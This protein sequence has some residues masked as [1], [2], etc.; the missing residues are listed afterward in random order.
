[1]TR[2]LITIEPN[3]SIMSAIR[4][5]IK[6]NIKKLAVVKAGHLV[7]VLSLLDLVPLLETQNLSL[8]GVPKHVKRIFSIYYDPKQQLRKNCPLTMVRGMTISCLG[9]KC[10]WYVAD[11]CVIINLAEKLSN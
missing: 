8:K 9:S 4:I 2:P 5:M 7:G 3:L 6:K 11:K 10:M 1:M